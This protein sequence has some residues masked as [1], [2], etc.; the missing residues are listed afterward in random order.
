MKTSAFVTVCLL[1]S[2]LLGFWRPILS[3]VLGE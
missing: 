1:V 3:F 2:V